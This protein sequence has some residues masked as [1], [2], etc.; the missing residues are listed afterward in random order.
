MIAV[1]IGVGF[2]RFFGGFLEAAGADAWCKVRD[3]V[4]ELYEARKQSAHGPEGN[5]HLTDAEGNELL[6]WRLPDAAFKQ[7]LQIDWSTRRP[8][9]L[10]WDEEV[11]KWTSTAEF[12]EEERADIDP[13]RWDHEQRRWVPT[14]PG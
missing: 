6:L 8:G 10:W 9:I 4:G 12:T 5:M 11:G 13:W 7:L 2:S 1:A 14:D 3:W